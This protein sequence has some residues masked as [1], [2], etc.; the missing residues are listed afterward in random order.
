MS[1]A[2]GQGGEFFVANAA[3]LRRLEG[4][5]TGLA[6][7]NTGSCASCWR[8]SGLA[9]RSGAAP[10]RRRRHLRSCPAVTCALRLEAQGA[11]ERGWMHAWSN[12]PGRTRDAAGRR[13]YDYPQSPSSTTTT[14]QAL[15]ATGAPV[16]LGRR[17]T[18]VRAR[19]TGGRSE[20][21]LSL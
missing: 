12:S 11:S 18:Q 9:S 2:R 8:P 10:C 16:P 14:R 17:Q 3:Q 20:P 6:A 13:Q 7:A 1:C 21:Q 4:G 19:G 5:R 15:L